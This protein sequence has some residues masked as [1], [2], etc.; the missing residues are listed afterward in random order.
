MPILEVEIVCAEEE[1]LV[2]EWAQ[3]I[4]DLAASVFET[5]PTQTWVKLRKLESVCYAENGASRDE[6]PSPVFVSVTKKEMGDTETVRQEMKALTVGIAEIL[7]KPGENVHIQYQPDA[8]GR[9]AFGG[10]LVE[11]D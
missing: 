8:A 11:K 2:Q 7:K 10:K 5:G 9:I 3:Q 4:A 1:K 6:V